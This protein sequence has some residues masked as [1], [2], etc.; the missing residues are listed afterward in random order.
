MLA[1]NQLAQLRERFSVRARR[2][3]KNERRKLNAIKNN[4]FATPKVAKADP[5]AF[6]VPTPIDLPDARAFDR[7]KAQGF[8]EQPE[9]NPVVLYRPN[10]RLARPS[11]PA[12]HTQRFAKSDPVQGYQPR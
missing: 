7:L 4:L 12:K 11:Y 2:I 1:P 6:C 8:Q 10:T 5:F 3:T 9:H